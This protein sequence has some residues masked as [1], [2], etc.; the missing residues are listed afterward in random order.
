MRCLILPIVI[1]AKF[2]LL[3]FAKIIRLLLYVSMHAVEHYINSFKETSLDGII[4]LRKHYFVHP[5]LINS[6]SIFSKKLFIKLLQTAAVLSTFSF[7]AGVAQAP[8]GTSDGNNRTLATRYDQDE[9][10][11]AK[12]QWMDMDCHYKFRQ[13]ATTRML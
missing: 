10:E 7:V 9:C 1:A 12:F 2:K 6:I 4:V 8:D 11:F 3:Q 5:C 13:F